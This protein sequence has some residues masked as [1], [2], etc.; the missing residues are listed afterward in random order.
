[1]TLVC[2]LLQAFS[3]SLHNKNILLYF[4]LFL[5]L[6]I[7]HLRVNVYGVRWCGRFL[8]WPQILL[9]QHLPNLQPGPATLPAH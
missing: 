1:M 9:F 2:A 8:K 4:L 5:N 3:L 7:S 6:S